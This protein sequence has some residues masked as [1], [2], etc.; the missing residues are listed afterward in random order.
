M[1]NSLFSYFIGPK[2]EN[3]E[4]LKKFV[5]NV[6]DYQAQW[7]KSYFPNDISLYE[8]KKIDTSKLENEL[9]KFLERSFKSIPSFH[10]RYSAQMLKD[11]SIPT[12]IGYLTFLLSNPNNHAYEGGPVTTEMEM[13]VI[14][15]MLKMV[16]YNEGWGHL[17]S[18]GS[19]ANLEALWAVRDFYSTSRF[20][21][22]KKGYVYFSEVSHYSWKRICNILAIENY[23]EIPVDKNF[24]MDLN[25]LEEKLKKNSALM[26]MANL[27][28]TG[29][30]SVDDINEILNLKKKYSFHLH[31]DAAYGG[32]FKSIILDEKNKII[33]YNNN[34]NISEFVYEQLKCISEADSITIDPH[35]QGAI[36]YGAG[37]V[38]YKEEKLRDVILNTAPYTYHKTDKPNIGMFTLE[39]SRPG[40]MAAACY[41][42]YKVFPLNQNG[43]GEILLSSLS[44]SKKFYELINSSN[45]YK[46]L[47]SPDLDINCFYRNAEEK[48]ISKIN[49]VTQKIYNQLSIESENPEFILSKFVLPYSIT[50]RIFSDYKNQNE[51]D[52]VAL[53]SVFMKHWNSSDDFYY[54]NL[55]FK[56][57]LKEAE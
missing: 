25:I 54:I 49:E 35:K 12:I 50:K 16:G 27:G 22:D 19:L 3:I 51:E 57:L 26:V 41:L 52:L 10:P 32:F 43:I 38:L 39:G 53:R 1:N 4:T 45:Q 44:S 21:S 29:T 30:G 37:A 55:L 34:L 31:I 42:T 2:A 47:H 18:G 48:N 36:S 24:R 6:L 23:K 13:E 28:S 8:N 15:M 40:A 56:K 9:K 20:Y 14:D 46:N 7:R 17:A 11:T 33:P 5:L